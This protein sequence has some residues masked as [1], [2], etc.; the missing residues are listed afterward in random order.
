MSRQDHRPSRREAAAAIGTV[1]AAFVYFLIFAQFGFLEAVRSGLP[2]PMVKPVM[3][4]MGAAGVA[5]S[6]AAVRGFALGRARASLIAGFAVCAVAA[7]VSL[8]AVSAAG[9]FMAAAL[10]GLG[11][12]WTTVT[13]ASALRPAVGGARLG[14]II[15]VGTGLAYGLCNVPALFAAGARAQAVAG[16][17][18]AVAGIGGSAALRFPVPGESSSDPDY[19]RAGVA[20]WVAIL[21]AL[22]GLDSAAFSLIQ[23]TPVLKAAT[24]AGGWRLEANA[25]VHLLVAVLTGYALDRRWVG[26]T[27]AAGAVMLLAACLLVDE[28]TRAFAEGA[29]LYTAGVSVYSTVLVFYPA[30]SH[31]PAVAAAVYA[32]AGWVGSAVGIGLAEARQALPPAA[33]A[34]A[35]SVVAAGL[36]VRHFLRRRERERNKFFRA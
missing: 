28:S 25:T 7:G 4:I 3:A 36:A 2:A 24:W 1:A 33:V 30:R 16:I 27:L 12:G 26:R 6:V 18:A 10:V 5:A 29:T 19:S 31:R 15:G 21:T 11:A 17:A 34:A 23:N 22:V 20:V 13:L 14:T 32:G 8:G 9:F 35:G